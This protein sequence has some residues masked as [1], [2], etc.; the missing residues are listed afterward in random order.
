[1]VELYDRM[2]VK[3][4]F[5]VRQW[6]NLCRRLMSSLCSKALQQQTI[7]DHWGGEP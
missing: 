3:T 2:G 5:S 7:Q 6:S 1:M 4:S